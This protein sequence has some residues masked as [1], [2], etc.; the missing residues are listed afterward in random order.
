MPKRTTS[1]LKLVQWIAVAVFA[2]R[3][4]RNGLLFYQGGDQTF[5]YTTAAAAVLAADRHRSRGTVPG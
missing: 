5:F 4:E 2:L 3:T 1:W